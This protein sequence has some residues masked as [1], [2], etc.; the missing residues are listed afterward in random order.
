MAIR[1]I[2][3]YDLKRNWSM[4]IVPH[5]TTNK[6]LNDILVEN[7]NKFTFGRWETEFKHGD[8]PHTFESC[9]WWCDHRGPIPR[10]WY[11]TKHA[12]CH[13]LVNFT[14]KL[15]MLVMPHKQWRIITSDEH[16]TVWDGVDTLFDF[17]WQAMGIPP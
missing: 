10:F 7:F 8:L 17:N 3:Y 12:A 14:L 11:Y 13:W 15:A 1:P 4:R 6:E 16:S 9:D 5:L 2:H